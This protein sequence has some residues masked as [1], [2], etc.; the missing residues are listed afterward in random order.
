MFLGTSQPTN[1][2]KNLNCESIPGDFK[3][4]DNVGDEKLCELI[5]SQLQQITR[6]IENLCNVNS[7]PVE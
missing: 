6:R 3:N 7:E 2:I 5:K 4:S 1:H